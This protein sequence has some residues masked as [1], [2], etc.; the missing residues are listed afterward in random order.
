MLPTA[1]LPPVQNQDAQ[2]NVMFLQHKW[3][4]RKGKEDRGFGGKGLT[5]VFDQMS[6]QISGP[7]LLL[8]ADFRS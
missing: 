4:P 2:H 1:P 3:A 7:K 8:C 5:E 6:A